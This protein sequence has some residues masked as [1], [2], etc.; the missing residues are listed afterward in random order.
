[1]QRFFGPGIVASSIRG[2]TQIFNSAIGTLNGPNFAT[3]TGIGI[4]GG[5]NGN[6]IPEAVQIEVR[7]LDKDG[8]ELKSFCMPANSK[9]SIVLTA[10]EI[11]TINTTTGH[12]HVKTAKN[13]GKINTTTG[14][15]NIVRCNE[16]G[17]LITTT[18]DVTVESCNTIGPTTST[19]GNIR[20]RTNTRPARD[21]SPKRKIKKAPARP[22]IRQ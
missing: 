9:L 20:V 15:V 6:N 8:K 12:V 18:G 17:T 5:A 7:A 10:P 14:E 1:M 13:I 19:L 22:S 11:R 3:V 16:I 4:E 21:S 2:G